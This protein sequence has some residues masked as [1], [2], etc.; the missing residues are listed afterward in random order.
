[1]LRAVDV[2][3]FGAG[4]LDLLATRRQAA[5][6]L[7]GPPLPVD[8]RVYRILGA[9]QAA[10]AVV[11]ARTEWRALGALVDLL[12]LASMVPVAVASRRWRRAALVQIGFAALMLRLARIR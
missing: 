7:G 12:H 9:R 6:E 4:A 1:M 8:A 10:Q 3:R 2:V 11:T 5:L